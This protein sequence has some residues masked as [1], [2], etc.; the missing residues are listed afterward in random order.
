MIYNLSSQLDRSRFVRRV[1]A[2]LQRGGRVEMRDVARRSLSQ[3]SY[4]HVLIAYFGMETGNDASYVK[5]EYYKKSANPE[6]FCEIVYDSLAKRQTCKLRSSADLS[7]EEM[8][9]SIERFRN[10]ASEVA[11]IYLPDVN[12]TEF[13]AEIESEIQRNKEYL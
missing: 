3:N 6:L 12:E 11:G 2:L 8:T 5:T 4:L 9:L 7:V 10:W 1:E 13:V